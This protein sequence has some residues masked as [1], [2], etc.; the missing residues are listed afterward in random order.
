[1]G[2][3]Y[4]PSVPGESI[5]AMCSDATNRH[6][7]CGDTRG[8]IRIWN[9][10]NFCCS[11]TSPVLFDSQPPPLVHSWQAHLSPIL[12]CE[13]MNYK[14]HGDF[15]LSAST[16][17]TARLWT[18][19]GEEIG[20]FG[21]REQWDIELLIS[22]RDVKEDE[23]IEDKKENTANDNGLNQS[24]ESKISEEYFSFVETKSTT[25]DNKDQQILAPKISITN[26]E[27]SQRRLSTSTDPHSEVHLFE[28]LRS[29]QFFLF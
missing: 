6:L 4:G 5:L 29:N 24:I 26:D 12:F 9:I 10:E 18:M 7:I 23:L 21:Q 14:G 1:M 8:E 17:H 11:T 16:D 3:F 28:R 22:S 27:Q 2:M 25:T 19:K 15:I 20:I 13:W